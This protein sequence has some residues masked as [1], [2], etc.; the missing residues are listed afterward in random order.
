V[1]ARVRRRA[2]PTGEAGVSLV[3]LLVT[4]IVTSIVATATVALVLGVHRANARNEARLDQVNTARNAVEVMTRGLRSAVRQ[5]QL[6]PKC[7]GCAAEPAVV[8]ASGYSVVFYTNLDNSG[9]AAGPRKVSYTVATTGATAGQLVEVVQRP[10]SSTPTATGYR[11]CTTDDSACAARR[12][13]RLLASGVRT[14]GTAPLFSYTDSTGAGLAGSN[15]SATQLESIVAVELTL[16]LV[17]IS[18]GA[19]DDTTYIQRVLLPNAQALFPH[20]EEE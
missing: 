6:L 19:R 8:S 3:E 4:I 16:R 14:D 18:P 20:E 2:A 15:L 5:S 12:S 9:N 13:T 1:N 10:D 7:P 11:Y 17:G